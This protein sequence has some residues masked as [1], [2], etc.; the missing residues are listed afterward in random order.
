MSKKPQALGL[1]E[2]TGQGRPRFGP[3]L[4][5][6]YGS[7]PSKFACAEE[8]VLPQPNGVVVQPALR[9]AYSHSASVGRRYVRPGSCSEASRPS[10]LQNETASTHV[11]AS[12]GKS[13]V[14]MSATSARRAP[15]AEKRDG[16]RLVTA[17]NCA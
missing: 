14:S 1:Y 12:T 8:M 16:L 13:P 2:P 6:R 10:L 3:C 4:P 15:L 11:G 17:S 7:L 5:R 9:Q